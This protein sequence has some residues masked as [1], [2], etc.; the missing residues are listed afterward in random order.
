MKATWHILGPGAIGSLFA[1][2]LQKAGIPVVLIGRLPATVPQHITLHEQAHGAQT[3]SRFEFPQDDGAAPIS[4]LLITVKAHQTEA[5]LKP[6]RRRLGPGSLILL[7]QNGMGAWKQVQQLCPQSTCLVATTTE[8]ANRPAPS[9]VVHAGLGETYIGALEPANQ[10]Q[11]AD[12]AQQWSNLAL[13]VNEDRHILQR[14]WQKLAINCAI[15]PLTVKYDCPNGELLTR[16]DAL[17][18]MEAVCKEVERVMTEVLGAATPN[19]FEIVQTVAEKTRHNIS[20]MLQ[21]ARKKQ[22]TEIDYITGYLM[23]EARRTGIDCPRN[24]ELYDEIK[25]L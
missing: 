25:R 10:P 13:S 6:L 8:G 16:A 2:H 18:D 23:A 3:Q 12:L 4:H 11:A 14:L 24:G 5:A 21:D 17:K 15:N 19:L 9:E 7:L 22:P 1:C 20:S